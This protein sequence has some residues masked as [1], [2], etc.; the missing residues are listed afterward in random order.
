MLKGTLGEW[1]DKK[2]MI[3]TFKRWKKKF[4]SFDKSTFDLTMKTRPYISKH[5]PQD[6][7]SHVLNR[8]SA[9]KEQFETEKFELLKVTNV[10]L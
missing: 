1:M 9:L 7:Q 8:Y 3:L 4:S 2:S 10:T 5:H 6:F